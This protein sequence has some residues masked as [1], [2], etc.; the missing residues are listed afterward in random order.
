M[1]ER[2]KILTEIHVLLAQQMEAV[3][4]EWMTHDEFVEYRERQQKI[5]E[6]I[7]RIAAIHAS[8]D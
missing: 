3:R 7:K 1:S 8:G 6:L 5:K 2:D 4:K